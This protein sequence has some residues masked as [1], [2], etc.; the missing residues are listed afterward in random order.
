[1][2]IYIYKIYRKSRPCFEEIKEK[3]PCRPLPTKASNSVLFS[4]INSTFGGRK[5]QQTIFFGT[6][7]VRQIRGR[8]KK[9]KKKNVQL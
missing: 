4:Q 6:L 2:Y 7:V 3:S 1:M 5:F 9:R 8:K